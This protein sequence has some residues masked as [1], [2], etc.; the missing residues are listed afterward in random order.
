MVRYGVSGS[1]TLCGALRRNFVLFG[2]P[3]D[4]LTDGGP[5][6]I[7]KAV[8]DLFSSWGVK[9]IVSSAYLASSNGRAELAVK[10][11]KRLLRDNVKSDG[12]IDTDKFVRAMLTKRN[13]PDSYSR[14][15]PA[16]IVLGRKLSDALP[17]LPKDEVF[18]KNEDSDILPT[19]Y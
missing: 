9:H 11:T 2:V 18:T 1:G 19:Y 12:S 6:F 10:A 5:D 17:V 16:E 14:L 8:K 13:T 4:C 15:S 7:S 3:A